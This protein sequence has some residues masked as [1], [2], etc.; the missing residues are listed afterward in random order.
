MIMIGFLG[1][2]LAQG[3]E[4]GPK[5]WEG[6]ANTGWL[7]D[8]NACGSQRHDAKGHRHAVV[9]FRLQAEPAWGGIERGLR[10]RFEVD[11]VGQGRHLSPDLGQLTAQH[12]DPIAFLDTRVRRAANF[13]WMFGEQTACHERCDEIGRVAQIEA[14][15]RLPIDLAQHGREGRIPLQRIAWRE[16]PGQPDGGVGDRARREQEGR[17]G[18]VALDGCVAWCC[19]S[20]CVPASRHDDGVLAGA[21]DA[22]AGVAHHV[23]GHLDVRHADELAAAACRKLDG[24]PFVEVR[25]DHEQSAGVLTRYRGVDLDLGRRRRCAA[26]RERRA[27]IPLQ[28]PHLDAKCSQGAGERTDG[29]LAHVLVAIDHERFVEKQRQARAEANGGTRIAAKHRISRRTPAFGGPQLDLVG[30]R[31][32]IAFGRGRCPPHVAAQRFQQPAE[33]ARIVTQERPLDRAGPGRQ[34]A[35]QQRPLRHALATRNFQLQC[36]AEEPSLGGLLG[37]GVSPGSWLVAGVRHRLR[38]AGSDASGRHLDE[39]TSR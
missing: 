26:E 7:C 3:V 1:R 39:A 12:R 20:V 36:H 18:P 15:D 27:A 30:G 13:G 22:G 32:P 9:G 14:V 35:D 33:I 21:L 31:V 6:L 37:R 23:E 34:R 17:G 19:L 24:Q 10:E 25:R 16:Q 2:A 5:V 38:A 28:M 4:H 29:T 8:A 11:T